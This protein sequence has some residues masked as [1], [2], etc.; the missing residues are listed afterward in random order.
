VTED[1]IFD[2][3]AALYARPEA[4]LIQV[5]ARCLQV[6]LGQ[7]RWLFPETEIDLLLPRSRV[8]ELP[9]GARWGGWPCCGL[10]NHALA[11]LPLLC[12][13]MLTTQ[14][15]LP[16]GPGHAFL[17]VRKSPVA[18]RV[19]G[20]VEM[21]SESLHQPAHDDHL[22]SLGVL[23]NGASIADLQRLNQEGR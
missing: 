13:G 2:Q 23:P 20:P 15:E 16:D 21:T 11:T 6:V 4:S 19:P 10:V 18:L 5:E 14:R 1:Q 7:R 22:W 9:A 12:W 17:V 3:R 8:T